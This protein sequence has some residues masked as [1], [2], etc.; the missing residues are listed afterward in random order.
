M[1]RKRILVWTGPQ[2]EVEVE[3]VGYKD[4][5]CIKD[6][7]EVAQ[8]LGVITQVIKKPEAQRKAK[9]VKHGHKLTAI[10]I[11]SGHCG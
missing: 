10:G 8:H 11:P 5:S 9:K 6:V 2:A 1:S 4:N 3:A 7:E